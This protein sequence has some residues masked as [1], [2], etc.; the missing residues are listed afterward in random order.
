LITKN[1]KAFLLSVFLFSPA[2]GQEKFI[3]LIHRK[4]SSAVYTTV[5]SLDNFFADPRIKEESKA[6]LRFRAGF[7]YNSSPSFNNILKVDFKIRLIKLEKRLGIFVESY[8]ERLTRKEEEEPV[9]IKERN[10]EQ[11]SLG[12]EYKPKKQKI[13]RHRFSVGITSSP[14]IYAKYFISNVPVIYKRWEITAYQWFRTEKKMNDYKLEER[15]QLYIDRLLAPDFVWR[16][17]LER[18]KDSKTPYQ[19]INYISSIRMFNPV[20]FYK[21]SLAI[22]SFAGLTQKKLINAEVSNYTLQYRIRANIYK[23]WAFFNIHT[24]SNWPKSRGFKGTPFIKV[25]FEFYFGKI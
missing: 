6:Y 5:S 23:D 19:V 18:Y 1:W 24:G 25:F 11:I 12:I 7:S 15:T 2:F 16:I 21:R 13:V 3:D 14:K 4:I 20:K 10:K 22:E 9:E 17:Y 8:K